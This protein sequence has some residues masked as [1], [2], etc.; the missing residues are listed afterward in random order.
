M[1]IKE[2]IKE[3]IYKI[4]RKAEMKKMAKMLTKLLEKYN[5]GVFEKDE[6]KKI[7]KTLMLYKDNNEVLLHLIKKLLLANDKSKLNT[8][9]FI[10]SLGYESIKGVIDQYNGQRTEQIATIFIDELESTIYGFKR[11]YSYDSI[12]G[13]LNAREYEK[14]IISISKSC[15]NPYV[16]S[17]LTKLFVEQCFLTKSLEKGLKLITDIEKLKTFISFYLDIKPYSTE[18]GNFVYTLRKYCEKD[19]DL[20]KT[21][22]SMLIERDVSDFIIGFNTR[23]L[24]VLNKLLDITFTINLRLKAYY[25]LKDSKQKRGIIISFYPSDLIERLKSIEKE[26]AFYYIERLHKIVILENKNPREVIDL[27]KNES[28]INGPTM[29][30]L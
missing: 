15:K 3:Q 20:L 13:L 10:E 5:S 28:D 24:E 6:V 1:R 2:F 18:Q 9:I 7:S 27:I 21:S 22:C 25:N 11:F 17:A 30:I 29:Q 19:F 8:L 12:K 16:I 14:A 23:Y 26:R 4:K